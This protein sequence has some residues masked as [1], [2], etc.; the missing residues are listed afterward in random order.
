MDFRGCQLEA[1]LLGGLQVVCWLKSSHSKCL[2][3]GNLTRPKLEL[4]NNILAPR[5]Y[6]QHLLFGKLFAF[7]KYSRASQVWKYSSFS[8]TRKSTHTGMQTIRTLST[9]NQALFRSRVQNNV[10]RHTAAV[11]RDLCPHIGHTEA[12]AIWLNW[13]SS[14][15]QIMQKSA[16]ALCIYSVTYV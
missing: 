14:L 16:A 1:W 12:L 11:W 3:P 8:I 2:S 10:T 13:Y 15:S 6:I 7:S 4:K 5:L 9:E